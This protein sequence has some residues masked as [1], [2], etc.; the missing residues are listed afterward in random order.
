MYKIGGG[1]R[2]IYVDLIFEIIFLKLLQ[3]MCN[4]YV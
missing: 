4:M 2:G 3:N 1:R